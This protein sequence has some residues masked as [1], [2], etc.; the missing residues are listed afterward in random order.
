MKDGLKPGLH[1]EL[2]LTVTHDLTIS[3]LGEGVTPVYSTPSLVTGMEEASRRALLPYLDAGEE[4]VGTK[5]NIQHIAATP[6]G[7]AVTIRSTL[8]EVNGRR[9]TFDLEAHDA[10]EKI[11]DGTH[12]RF[13]IDIAKFAARVEAKKDG[14]RG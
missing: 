9:C 2:T 7:M 10:R 1:Y 3:H 8:V 4:S 6:L 13:I 14:V 11:G 5:V 12:E